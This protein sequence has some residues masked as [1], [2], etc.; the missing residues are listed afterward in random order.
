MEKYAKENGIED[1]N[2]K[3]NFNNR[4]ESFAMFIKTHPANPDHFSTPSNSIS[5]ISSLLLLCKLSSL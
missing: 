3:N 4:W 1:G 2:D 5:W